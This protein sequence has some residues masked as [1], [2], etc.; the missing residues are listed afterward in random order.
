MLRFHYE[1]AQTIYQVVLIYRYG[2][3]NKSPSDEVADYVMRII[4]VHKSADDAG[5]G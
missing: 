5:I 4:S 2:E 3:I 1:L